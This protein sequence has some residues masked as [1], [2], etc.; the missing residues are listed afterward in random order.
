MK[1][2]LEFPKNASIRASR[3]PREDGIDGRNVRRAPR[4]PHGLEETRRDPKTDSSRLIEFNCSRFI[5]LSSVKII[6]HDVSIFNGLKSALLRGWPFYSRFINTT[7]Q[8]LG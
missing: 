5:T 2:T 1:M 8:R 7:F 3:A 4:V 6:E